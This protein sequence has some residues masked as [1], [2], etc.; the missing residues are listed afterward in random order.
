M[1]GW[2]NS[3]HTLVH[4]ES[5]LILP[6]RVLKSL[7]SFPPVHLSILS[8]P[9][10][11]PV[12]RYSEYPRFPL[13]ATLS[14]IGLSTSLKRSLTMVKATFFCLA[15]ASPA[16]GGVVSRDPNTQTDTWSSTPSSISS[17]WGQWSSASS[18]PSTP[19]ATSTEWASPTKPSSSP[20]TWG[21]WSTTS[22][23]NQSTW[24]YPS[25][26]S[27]SSASQE[28][29]G[30]WGYAS[31]PSSSVASKETW[32]SP[33]PS[34]TWGEWSTPASSS[35]GSYIS[36]TSQSWGSPSPSQIWGEWSGKGW[37]GKHH[38]AVCLLTNWFSCPPNIC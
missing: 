21:Q 27:T 32:R 26:P 31:Q 12:L 3:Q 35:G 11:Y 29:W 2:L 19:S 22:S 4:T 28:T 24:G 1:R 23:S 36:P 15:L 7:S 14:T 6:Q 13:E 33:Y 25:K 30:S 8:S 37:Q 16:L 20:Q 9:L 34:K 17:Q 18:S 38:Q 5:T 10:I